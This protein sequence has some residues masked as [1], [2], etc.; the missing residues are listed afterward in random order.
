[1]SGENDGAIQ[2]VAMEQKNRLLVPSDPSST[3]QMVSPSAV[4]RINDPNDLVSLAQYVQTA[5]DFTRATVGGKLELIAEQIKALQNQAREV[6]E[7]AKRDVELNH[8][9]CNFKRI[10]GKTYHLYRK[11]TDGTTYFSM[12]SPEEW[13]G[14]Q[15]DSYIDSYRLEYDMSWTPVANIRQRE[16]RRKFDAHLLGLDNHEVKKLYL[17]F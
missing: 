3:N 10:P 13:G 11:E 7:V 16:E 1:M 6:L 5:D 17:E 8:A 15:T 2:T 9:K 4:H 14:R 12:L